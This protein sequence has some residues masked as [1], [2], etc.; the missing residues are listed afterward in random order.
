LKDKDIAVANY[1]DTIPYKLWVYYVFSYPRYSYDTNNITESVNFQLADI[2]K[3]LPL[4]MMDEIYT[5][6]MQK[7]YERHHRNQC[8]TEIADVPLSK[9]KDR[10]ANSQRYRVVQSRNRVYQVQIPDSRTKC[11]VNLKEQTCE[12]T[13]FEEYSSLCTHAIAACRF[14]AE[15]LYKLFDKRYS[16]SVYRD[17]YSYFVQPISIENLQSQDGILPPV[18]KKQRGRPA[19]KQIRKG[20]WKQK[21]TKCSKYSRTGYNI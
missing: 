1:V 20:A 3:L 6:I 17:T 12:C 9:F 4:Q 21:E 15:D 10:L 7:V 19:T 11:I 13:W 8:S 18:F 16:T 2:R 14:E 5:W